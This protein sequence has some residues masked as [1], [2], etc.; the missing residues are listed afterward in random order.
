MSNGK[1]LFEYQNEILAWK[2]D[3]KTQNEPGLTFYSNPDDFIQVGLWNHPVDSVLNSHI[4]NIHSKKSDRTS[5]ALFVLS[6]SIHADIYNDECKLLESTIVTAG[7]LLVCIAGGHGYRILSEN[8]KV[9]EI[10]NGPYPGPEIDRS[11][12]PTQCSFCKN[13]QR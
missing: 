1:L 12:F 8:T 2:I 9:L 6:G 3:L 5:E 7:E 4:H 13:E 10:K 11:P